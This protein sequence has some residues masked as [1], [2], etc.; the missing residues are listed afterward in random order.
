M[1]SR[2][3][4]ARPAA[5]SQPS[6][7]PEGF[8]AIQGR[9]P[10]SSFRPQAATYRSRQLIDDRARRCV[11]KRAAGRRVVATSVRTTVGVV[12]LGECRGSR[13]WRAASDYDGDRCRGYAGGCPRSRPAEPPAL[14]ARIGPGCAVLRRV[15]PDR[16]RRRA[17]KAARGRL[18]VT[19][20]TIRPAGAAM[21]RPCRS[22]SP[23]R[24][25]RCQARPSMSRP[26]IR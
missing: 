5:S 7:P 1:I 19:P 4:D 12:T 25:K 24:T 8:D 6:A 22:G 14:V 11:A 9:P 26:A 17:R 3:S 10:G 21:A 20:G 13:G 2:A 15:G 16:P 23:G 18:M